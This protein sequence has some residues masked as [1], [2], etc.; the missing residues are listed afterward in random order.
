MLTPRALAMLMACVI[1]GVRPSVI[2]DAMFCSVMSQSEANS[3]LVILFSL[4]RYFTLLQKSS[5]LKFS[6]YGKIPSD[7]KK[8]NKKNEKCLTKHLELSIM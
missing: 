6:I 4:Q 1:F 2:W 5:M 7:E 3:L 8:I